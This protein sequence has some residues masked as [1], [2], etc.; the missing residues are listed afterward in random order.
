MF[1]NSPSFVYNSEQTVRK[2]KEKLCGNMYFFIKEYRNIL[3]KK[4]QNRIIFKINKR[5]E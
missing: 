5:L 2:I 1:R 4:K 3:N